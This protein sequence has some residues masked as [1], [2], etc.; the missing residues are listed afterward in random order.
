MFWGLHACIF[1]LA[2]REF[3][4]DT[5]VPSDLEETVRD[6]IQLFLDGAR[7]TLPRV[8]QERQPGSAS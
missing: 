5:P 7:L 3:I 8:M 4:Y 2:I 1:Y 6:A